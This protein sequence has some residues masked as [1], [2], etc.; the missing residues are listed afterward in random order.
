MLKSFTEISL[1]RI[2]LFIG[3]IILLQLLTTS[4][5]SQKFVSIARGHVTDS[6]GPLS[7][8]SV[9]LQGAT[10]GVYTDTEGNFS[11]PVSNSSQAFWHSVLIFTHA[12]YNTQ[13]VRVKN[14]R[15]IKVNMIPESVKGNSIPFPS[16]QLLTNNDGLYTETSWDLDLMKYNYTRPADNPVSPG[17]AYNPAFQG[18]VGNFV[19]VIGE[20]T[21]EAKE[22]RSINTLGKDFSVNG[23]NGKDTRV[24]IYRQTTGEN[25]RSYNPALVRERDDYLVCTID[26]GEPYGMYLMWVENEN[27]AG[28]PVRI[29]APEATWIGPEHATPG[30]SVNLY[31]RNLSH[32]NDTTVSYIFIRKWGAG[33]GTATT[34]VSVSR[35]NPYRVTFTVPADVVTNSDYEVWVHNGHGGQYGW[36]GPMKL[37]IDADNPYVWNGTTRNVSSFG[38]TG[39]GSTDDSKSIQDA[40]NAASDG[41]KIYF[42]AGTF[43]L[44]ANALS[45]DKKL[46]FEGA[47][48]GKTTII[49]DTSFHQMQMLSVLNFPS[50]IMNLKFRTLKID[51]TGLHYL[52]RASGGEMKNRPRGFIV[53]Q[54]TFET[55]PFGGNAMFRNLYGIQ[56]INTENVDDITLT[57]NTFTTQV[58]ACIF[59]GQGVAIKNNTIYGNW[60]VTHGNGNLLFSFPGS[61]KQMDLSNNF[62]QS[63]DHEGTLD[64]GDQIIVRAIVFQSW[65]GGNHDRIYIGSNNIDRAGNPWDNS[66]EIILFELPTSLTVYSPTSVGPATITLSGTWRSN[67]LIGQTAAIIKNTGIGQFRR[68]VANEGNKITLDRPWDVMPDKTSILSL[69]TSADNVVIYDN[70]VNGIP[71]YYEQE[72]ATSG[73]QLYGAAFNNVIVKNSFSNVHYGI[74]IH[75][76]SA[77]PT[78]IGHSTGSMGNLI[79]DNTVNNAIYGLMSIITMYPEVMPLQIPDDIPWSA[80]VNNVFRDNKISNMRQ[81]TVNSVKHGGY[82]IIVGQIYN[83]WQEPV[84]NGPWVREILI[85]HNTVTD[86]AGKYMWLRQHQQFTTA[87]KNIFVDNNKYPN[88]TGIYFSPQN[89]DAVLTDNTFSAN[90]DTIFGGTLPGPCLQISKRSLVFD[91]S[92]NPGPLSQTLMIKNAG[93]G[94]LNLGLS[95]DYKWMDAYLSTSV[96]NDKN[97]SSLLTVKVSPEGLQP[98]I[99]YGTITVYAGTS[100]DHQVLSVKLIIGR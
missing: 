98:G 99:Y 23:N 84:W 79:T 5:Y 82:G 34:P 27:G 63:V 60:K 12:G 8:V 4:L 74:Y 88:T 66:G 33:P 100:T 2:L 53:Y 17:D 72:S 55:A 9:K 3:G 51:G 50:Q 11:V 47:G 26:P 24:W 40:I 52:V 19:P 77:H 85:E 68:I 30:S 56:C 45:S 7:G 16:P 87:R 94:S 28:Y 81:F 14:Q 15:M 91:I 37:H 90:I 25:A 38:A 71:N 92:G 93:T 42:P 58:A 64:D 6:A 61:I 89:L 67:S 70:N 83:D 62:F 29:N 59:A 35:V 20:Y 78:A 44:M 95:D 54:S 48:A 18:T 73:I 22:D 46:S 86:A 96:I 49:T 57:N 76:F 80:N 21:T 36:S 32:N 10:A 31:G 13:N 43:R 1:R 69:N 39:N 75:G 97:E 65:H 41:D